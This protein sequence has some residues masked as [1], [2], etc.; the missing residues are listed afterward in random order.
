MDQFGRGSY[1]QIPSQ[2]ALFVDW[3]FDEEF[4]RQDAIGESDGFAG[5]KSESNAVGQ[6][7]WV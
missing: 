1:S 6:G 7:D 2:S 5:M 3:N 4:L